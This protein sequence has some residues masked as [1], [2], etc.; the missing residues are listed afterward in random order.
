VQAE[1]KII[2]SI[3]LAAGFLIALA[4]PFILYALRD[5]RW[6]QSAQMPK[7]IPVEE[8]RTFTHPCYR[9]VSDCTDEER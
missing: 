5:E 2:Y 3:I 8:V 4:L 9:G 1:S 6:K 7:R